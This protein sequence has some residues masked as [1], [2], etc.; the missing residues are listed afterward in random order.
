MNPHEPTPEEVERAR[1][2]IAHV[3]PHLQQRGSAWVDVDEVLEW[4]VRLYRLTDGGHDERATRKPIL[5]GKCGRRLGHAYASVVAGVPQAS[6]VMGNTV[7]MQRPPT[8]TRQDITT[9]MAPR[10]PARD[11]YQI[12]CHRKCGAHQPVT[13]HRLLK[14][15]VISGEKGR[16]NIIVGGGQRAAIEGGADL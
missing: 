12:S 7:G 1:S 10:A 5:C 11:R 14:A 8:G 13:G 2:E 15:F 16:A 9:V 3:L 6:P 4:W